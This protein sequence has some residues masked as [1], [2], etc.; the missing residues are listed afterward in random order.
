[1]SLINII[2]CRQADASHQNPDIEN[3]PC[4]FTVNFNEKL[5]LEDGDEVA[6]K[7]VYIDSR[8]KNTVDTDR[9]LIDQTNNEWNMN[10]IFYFTDHYTN[11][12]LV[13]QDLDTLSVADKLRPRGFHNILSYEFNAHE[14]GLKLLTLII[15]DGNSTGGASS[16][17]TTMTT[18]KYGSGT[19]SP[20]ELK[21]DVLIKV[22]SSKTR[23]VDVLNA[24][25]SPLNLAYQPLSGGANF[26]NEDFSFIDFD[27]FDDNNINLDEDGGL[28]NNLAGEVEVIE[29]GA[30]YR[31]VVIN[32]KFDIPNGS[33]EPP[34]LAKYITDKLSAPR[35]T[36]TNT[37]PIDPTKST[38]VFEPIPDTIVDHYQNIFATKSP[39]LTS[40]N[41]LGSDADYSMDTVGDIQF[42]E[43]TGHSIVKFSDTVAQNYMIGTNQMSLIYDDGLDKFVF[44][45]Q[46][47]PILN[48]S[49]TAS[50]IKFQQ[51][52]TGSVDNNTQFFTA[53]QTSGVAFHSTGSVKCQ[54]LMFS[55]MGFDPKILTTSGVVGQ[56]LSF[57]GGVKTNTRLF[58]LALEDGV[59]ITGNLSSIDAFFTKGAT[60][61]VAPG[62]ATTEI[63]TENLNSIIGVDEKGLNP[64]GQLSNAYYM[65]EVSGLPEI[66]KLTSNENGSRNNKIK[67]IVSKYYATSDYTTDGG[68]GSINYVHSGITQFVDSLNIRILNPD[69]SQ[70]TDIG[71]DNTVFLELVK[72]KRE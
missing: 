59:N 15:K 35:W 27:K 55:A 11:A 3:S 34:T 69:L 25:G 43:E 56:P 57:G 18:H 68:A 72:N 19:T 16:F 62:M 4:D 14:A 63:E 66:K 13:I 70:A 54:N 30:V 60:F 37:T 61:N 10:H 52:G 67:S 45:Q 64:G 48:S 21:V 1:M 32:T 58:G 40:I 42:V 12:D 49:G 8:K 33:Y 22:R 24:D 46:H 17:K 7:Q 26:S 53:T 2:E 36:Q 28:I 41:Q 65:V 47:A 31:P 44:E 29:S 5:K 20:A 39:F 50:I 9:I 23:D 38:P 6:I 51:K 71:T